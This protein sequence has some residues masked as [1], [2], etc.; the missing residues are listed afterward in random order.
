LLFLPELSM[1]ITVPFMEFV[2]LNG[3]KHGT[4]SKNYHRGSK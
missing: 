1:D 3:R 4:R 2:T